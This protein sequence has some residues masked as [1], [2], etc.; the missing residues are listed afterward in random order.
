[1]EPDSC[2]WSVWQ[3]ERRRS[4]FVP[5]PPPRFLPLSFSPSFPPPHPGLSFFRYPPPRW[6]TGLTHHRSAWRSRGTTG[7]V[8]THFCLCPL[9]WSLICLLLI[10]CESCW[11]SSPQ[12][13]TRRPRDPHIIQ[14]TRTYVPP[15]PPRLWTITALYFHAYL[16]VFYGKS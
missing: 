14:E 3:T 9:V 1:M 2:V 12:T 4:L 11:I 8:S 6:F 15:L 5:P 16:F 13:R 7:L 10:R